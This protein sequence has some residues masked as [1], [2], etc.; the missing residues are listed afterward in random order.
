[1]ETSVIIST[2]DWFDHGLDCLWNNNELKK[3]CCYVG[4][5]KSFGGGYRN[6]LPPLQ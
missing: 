2:Q 5:N 1:M 4:D 3:G 6:V